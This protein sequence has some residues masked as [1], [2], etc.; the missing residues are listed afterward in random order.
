M[1]EQE[2]RILGEALEPDLLQV[3]RREVAQQHRNLPVLHQL[4]GQ[5]GIAAGDFLGDER[6]GLH[7]RAGL[8]LDAAEFLRHAERADADLV[9]AD[10]N[11]RRQP[12]LRGHDPF[13][14]PV[15]ADERNH[16]VVDEVAARLPHQALLFGEL[17][18]LCVFLR[19]RD[20]TIRRSVGLARSCAL[21]WRHAAPRLPSSARSCRVTR[22]TKTRQGRGSAGRVAPSCLFLRH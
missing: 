3:A 6:E 8:E 1:G 22:G 10:Q 9:G 15:A 20:R 12:V 5:T 21:H 4:V 18:H 2:L 7:F 19:A 14:L 11:F 13:A 16:H 17:G